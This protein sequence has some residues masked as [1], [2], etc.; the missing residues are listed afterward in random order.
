MTGKIFVK[1][2]LVH[3]LGMLLLSCTSSAM[4]AEKDEKTFIPEKKWS[5]ELRAK[6]Y[7]ASHT[8]YEFGNPFPPFH[9]PLSRL[10]FPLNTLWAGGEIR[11]KFSRFSVGLEAFGAIPMES[12]GLMKDS[13]WDD[14]SNPELKTI[15]STSQCSVEPSYMVRGDVDLK[16]GDWL[17]IPAWFDL[18]PVAGVRWQRFKLMVHDGVQTELGKPADPLPGNSIHFEQT[19]WQYFLGIRADYDME[20]HIKAPRLKLH[21]QLDCAYVDGDNSDHHL[22]RAGKRMTYEKTRGSAVHASFGM[23][24]GLTANINAGLDFEY[25]WIRSE[26]T[27]RLENDLY[28]IDFS[29]DNGVKVWSEQMNIMMSLEYLF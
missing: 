18:R 24:A 29:F 27:H 14:E 1:C 3:L 9:A 16:I 17:D 12:D 5:V 6:R 21:G 28:G 23:K 25:L 13:D 8:S 7:F 10:E 22:L 15:Y 11:R 2:V 4:A 20:K 26:G 19:Y